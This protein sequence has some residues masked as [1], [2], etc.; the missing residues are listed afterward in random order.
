MLIRTKPALMAMLI[1]LGLGLSACTAHP[2]PK[3]KLAE[4][5]PQALEDSAPSTDK[6]ETEAPG[7]TPVKSAFYEDLAEKLQ[8]EQDL[9]SGKSGK[10]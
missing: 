9:A 6:P 3:T 1:T 4:T 5:V 2:K 7:K 8:G 10:P